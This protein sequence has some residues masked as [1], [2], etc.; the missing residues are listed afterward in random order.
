M[1]QIAHYLCDDCH[2]CWKTGWSKTYR[3]HEMYDYCSHCTGIELV[4]VEPYY[5]ENLVKRADIKR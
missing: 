4:T 2:T 3:L 1:R 5:V